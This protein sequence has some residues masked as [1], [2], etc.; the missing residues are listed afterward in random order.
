MA[1]RAF[2]EVDLRLMLCDAKGYHESHEPGRFVIETHLNNQALA[3]D[4]WNP[5]PLSVF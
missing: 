4:L 5:T 1:D 3:C 2:N